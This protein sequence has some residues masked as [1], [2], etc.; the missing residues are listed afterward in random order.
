MMSAVIFLDSGGGI[1]YR[2]GAVRVRDYVVP[3]RKTRF[4][5]NLPAGGALL[6]IGVFR[7]G[8]MYCAQADELLRHGSVPAVFRILAH[9]R[10]CFR[11]P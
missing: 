7:S 6:R 10:R 3:E 9:I 8:T 4:G 11:R 1:V 5:Y 2:K